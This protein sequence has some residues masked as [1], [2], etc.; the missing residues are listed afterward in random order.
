MNA[1][2]FAASWIAM[3]TAHQVADHWVQTHDQASSK[4]AAGWAGARA[5]LAHV[6]VYTLCLTGTVV[7]T[8]ALLGLPT[9]V[10]ALAA[11]QLLSAVTHY[12]ADRRTPLAWLASKL[13]S[14]SMYELGRPRPGKDDNTVLGTGAYALDQS[15]H[16]LWIFVAALVTAL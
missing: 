12:V 9:N 3:F 7:V 6:A 8:L 2:V 10:W 14:T 11:G 15:F 5:C 1:A 4:G 13:G 16:M